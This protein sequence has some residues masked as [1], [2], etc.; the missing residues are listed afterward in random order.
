MYHNC[1]YG[2][3]LALYTEFYEASYC[4]V[5]DIAKA[6]K[7][8]VDQ[9]VNEATATRAHSELSNKWKCAELEWGVWAY[10]THM[11]QTTTSF[12]S[13]AEKKSCQ[14]NDIGVGSYV[15]VEPDVSPGNNSQGRVG[16]VVFTK[17]G[18][19]DCTSSVWYL[20][21]YGVK[22][23]NHVPYSR[24]TDLGHPLLGIGSYSCR[25]SMPMADDDQECMEKKKQQ[26]P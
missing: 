9:E 4:Y 14:T 21:N 6:S 1:S 18:G 17:G 16:Y 10:Q 20:E 13:P 12:I 19:A 5:E 11:S 25:H 24:L 15:R 26:S 2:C 7:K 8:K 23:Y 22:T 3:P